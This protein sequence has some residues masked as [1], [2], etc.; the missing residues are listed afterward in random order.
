MDTQNHHNHH[1][2]HHRT[3]PL[4]EGLRTMFRQSRY[5]PG[6]PRE[7]ITQRVVSKHIMSIIPFLAAIF[8]LAIAGIVGSYYLS[9]YQASIS[10]AL[11]LTLINLGG[12]L[13]MILLVF[14][15]FSILWI[16]R[17]NKLVI[18]NEHIV[19]IDQTGLFNRRVSALRLE[20]IQDIS[21]KI[22]GPSQT[23]F[24]YGTLTIQ[25]AGERKNFIMD[26]IYDPF[27]LEHYILETRKKYYESDQENPL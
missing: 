24:Q 8:I 16:W 5:Y 1:D 26:Y 4:R 20:E 10:D 25:T 2:N 15:F 19:D 17:R 22:L 14:L 7:E 27:E 9:V 18:T 6:Q 21:A 12:F 3:K 23:I 13:F 11:T